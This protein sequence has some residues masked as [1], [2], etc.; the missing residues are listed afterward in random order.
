MKTIIS[1][2]D[3]LTIILKGLISISGV[4]LM[5]VTVF[6]FY[7]VF[8][9]FAFDRPTPGGPEIVELIM[10]LIIFCGIAFVQFERRHISIDILTARL[11]ERQKLIIDSIALIL[12]AVLF[13]LIIWRSFEAALTEMSETGILGIPY[14]PFM[15]LVPFGCSLLFLQLL[16]Q[17]LLI[18]SEGM[19]IGIKA[20]HW[21][22]TFSVPI[23]ISV[24]V[25]FLLNVSPLPLSYPLIGIIGL[26]AMFILFATGM[27]IGFAL[28]A[29]GFIFLTFLRGLPAGFSMLGQTWFETVASFSWSPIILFTFMGFICFHS[30]LGGDL[31]YSAYKWIGHLKGGLCLS[32]VGACTAFGAVVGDPVTGS[33][34][35]TTVSLPEM[36][37]YK[38]DDALSLGTLACSGT[39]GVLIPPSIIFITYGVIAEQSIGDLFMAGIFPGIICA[40]LFMGL[41]YIRCLLNPEL[42]PAAERSSWRERFASIKASA[43]IAILFLIIIGGI[44]G[45]IFTPSEGGGIGAF[46][47]LCIALIMRRLSW[48]SFSNAVMETAKFSVMAFTL[49]GGAIMFA[50]FIATSNIPYEMAYFVEDLALPPILILLGMVIVIFI[51]G[52]FLPVLPIILICVPVFLPMAK[53]FNWDMIWFGVIVTLLAA[54]GNIT[55]PFGLN[56]FIL[57]GVTDV[58]VALMYRA[59]LPFC[60]ALFI[61]IILIIAFPP[62]SIWLPYALR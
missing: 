40:L 10:V 19:K 53:T 54:V 11:K 39:I 47:A 24:L 7:D 21:V 57:K 58:P 2:L 41:I 43:P 34:T 25:G 1:I 33:V 30:G 4:A 8:M 28:M 52:C 59:A 15:F 12:S 56:L 42:G 17:I 36:R 55:P 60:L 3:R 18:L 46:G 29:A 13:I 32:A 62:I 5:G 9:R 61:C 38:Y 50:Y 22:L 49:L 14:R 51:L 31:F 35:M 26:L 6:I 16:R 37:K 23:L 48:Q 20:G 27:P 44:Y 45:G